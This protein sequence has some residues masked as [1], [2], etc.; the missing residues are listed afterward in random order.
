MF[1]AFISTSCDGVITMTISPLT[2]ASGIALLLASSSGLQAA[3]A[4]GAATAF[5]GTQ[6][7]SIVE[8][9]HSFYEAKHK[10]RDLG[11]YAIQTERSTPPYSFVACKRGQRYHIH[12]DYYGDLVQVDEAG[13]CHD[14]RARYYEPRPQQYEGRYRD[15]RYSRYNRYN[16]DRGDDG[17]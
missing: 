9:V 16:R 10:L 15:N 11:Y 6:A 7:N 1:C 3:G 17:Y 5:T 8:R 12:V 4:G 2:I 13:S 14:Y